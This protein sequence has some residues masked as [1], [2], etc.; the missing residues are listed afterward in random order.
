MRCEPDLSS[1]PEQ[2]KKGDHARRSAASSFWSEHEYGPAVTA[3]AVAIASLVR[4]FDGPRSDGGGASSTPPARLPFRRC[5]SPAPWPV[6]IVGIYAF[7]TP[8]ANPYVQCQH[9]PRV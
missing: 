3:A 7:A 1:N 9:I 5:C 4:S 6:V 8:P 2:K